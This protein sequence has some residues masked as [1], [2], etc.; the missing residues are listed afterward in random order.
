MRREPAR[1]AM[2]GALLLLHGWGDHSGRFA[3]PAS[4]FA[5]RGISVYA[6]DQRGHGRTPGRRGHFERF[7]QFLADV[8]ALR[9]H[10]TRIE[11][12][13]QILLGHSFGG[14]VTLRYLETA[15]EQLAG[16]IAVAPF[17]DFHV[18][19]A[20]WKTT[21]AR[22]VA[23]ILP[24]V[25]IATGLDYESI[26]RDPAVYR[27]FH[28]DPLCHEVMTPRAYVEAMG[29][30]RTLAAERERIR[31]P[32]CFLIAG[33]DRIV[34]AGAAREFARTLHADTSIVELA[35]M[36]HNV[37]YEPDRARVYDALTPW[38]E[39]ALREAA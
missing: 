24:R 27:V 6:I 34:S 17:V 20:R 18:P 36:Y 7:A 1:G 21:L 25:P 29:A 31:V 12:G 23:D 5:S 3:E 26:S 35:G 4:W 15:P 38:L 19:P 14:F 9:R 16:A 33:D 37:F 28:D 8:A 2:R 22:L 30:L 10:V 39:R 11:P 13:P 32:V